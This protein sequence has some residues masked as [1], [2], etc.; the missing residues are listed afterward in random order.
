M[1]FFLFVI[2]PKLETPTHGRYIGGVRDKSAPTDGWH[3][4]LMCI[5]QE[6]PS[7]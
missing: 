4:I 5:I 2:I 7:S 6:Q 1:N 3:S